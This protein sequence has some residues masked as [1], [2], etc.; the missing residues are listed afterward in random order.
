MITQILMN[1]A[2]PQAWETVWN[3][4]KNGG[5]F[6][7]PI[8]ICSVLAVAVVAY[9]IMTLTKSLIIPS[10]LVSEVEKIEEHLEK[11]SL[12]GLQDQFTAGETSL[13]RLCQVALHNA[14]RTQGEVQEAVQSAAREEIV[15]MN[16]GMP[17]LEVVITIA[18][19]LGLLGT[20]SG[21][22]IVFA[23]VGQSA[24]H[25][26]VG[27]GIAMALNTTV[28][29]LAVAVPTVIAHSHFNRKIELMAARLEVLM[30]KVTSACHQH[31]FF[32]NR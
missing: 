10:K 26:S 31:V 21:L 22:V 7:V 29:G 20:A 8:L 19:L 23:S 12:N 17:T 18:P 1:N 16:T 15:K 27:Q 4:F 14:G 11:G 25:A 5:W 28:A 6:M 30:G 24:D 13:A 9:K 2:D 3:F 32:K